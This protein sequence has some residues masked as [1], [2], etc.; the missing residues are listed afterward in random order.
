M[1]EHL[2]AN[3]ATESV[4]DVMSNDHTS[5]GHVGS[6]AEPAPSNK[7]QALESAQLL[8]IGFILPNPHQLRSSIDES[9]LGDL[10]A[11][12]SE[13]GILEPL[14][15]C[16]K[17]RKRYILIAGHRRYEAARKVNLTHV[18]CI[19]LDLSEEDF[20]HYS[21]IEN[22]QR[23]DL[24]VF[25]EAA[26]I[27]ELITHLKLT[28]RDVAS[29]L[30]KSTGYISER[31]SLLELPEDVQAAI[32]DGR[33]SLKK[34]I[35]LARMPIEKARRKLL[36]K[37]GSGDLE[38]F[39]GLIEEEFARRKMKRKA[40]EKFDLLPGLRAFSKSN[41]GIHVYKDRLNVKFDSPQSLYAMLL[42][43]IQI[44]S[45]DEDIQEQS[46]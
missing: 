6:E 36:E 12:I 44:L 46:K 16:K 43:I 29:K 31:M 8:P 2:K 7:A 18:P 17:G 13:V 41:D 35:E 1:S 15:V 27:R 39:K 32:A 22:L 25:E 4:D 19:V 9:S 45:E 30:G 38:Q 42:Q 34:G 11:S 28:Y 40:Y 3:A 14:L 20:L 5:S 26:A 24:T 37:G 10:E 33:I 21:L 23:A